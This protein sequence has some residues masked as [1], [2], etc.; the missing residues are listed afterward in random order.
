VKSH[1]SLDFA[2]VLPP[3]GTVE[4]IEIDPASHVGGIDEGPNAVSPVRGDGRARVRWVGKTS[5]T[6]DRQSGTP[7]R[8][9]RT[10]AMNSSCKWAV[11][12][13]YAGVTGMARHG[14][15]QGRNTAQALSPVFSHLANRAGSLISP[16][17]YTSCTIAQ[18]A[19]PNGMVM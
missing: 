15:R 14:M 8:R 13:W 4:T 11:R 2:F 9:V 16:S 19:V 12:H 5:D 18:V 6:S 7:T 3:G 1:L 10:T 17:E